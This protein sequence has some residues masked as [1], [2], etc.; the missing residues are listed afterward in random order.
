[1]KNSLCPSYTAPKTSGRPRDE[2]KI[3]SSVEKAME[4]KNKK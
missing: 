2:K 4:K 1:M 3:K